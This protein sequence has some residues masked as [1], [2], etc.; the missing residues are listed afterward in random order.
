[1]TSEDQGTRGYPF[2]AIVGHERLRLALL[3]CA[4]GPRSGAC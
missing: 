3:L 2:S 4:V 1:M